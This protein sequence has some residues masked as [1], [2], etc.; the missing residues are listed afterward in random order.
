MEV[1]IGQLK[2]IFRSGGFSV[3]VDI[4][5]HELILNINPSNVDTGF[6]VVQLFVKPIK[7]S[8]RDGK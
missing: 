7:Y 2:F 8:N 1:Q 6:P 4:P 5:E 3:L